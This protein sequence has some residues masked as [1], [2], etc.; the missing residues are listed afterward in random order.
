MDYKRGGYH[1]SSMRLTVCAPVSDEASMQDSKRAQPLFLSFSQAI[2][3]KNSMGFRWI[4]RFGM[5][6]HDKRRTK[7]RVLIYSTGL[8]EPV[9]FYTCLGRKED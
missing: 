6:G 4:R 2:T 3:T 5:F 8:N 9:A 7:S 1:H